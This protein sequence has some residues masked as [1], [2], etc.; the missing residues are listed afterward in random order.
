MR[1]VLFVIPQMKTAGTEKALLGLLEILPADKYQ[2]EIRMV[3]AQGGLLGSIQKNVIVDELP[4]SDKNK[5]IL[6][7]GGTKATILKYLKKFKLI[8]AVK[9]FINKRIKKMPVAELL[10]PFS[11]LAPLKEEYDLAVCFTMHF[12]F[13][14]QY[15]ARKVKAKKKAVWIHNDFSTTSLH[16]EYM[17][18]DLKQYDKIFAVSKQL[19]QE[20]IERCPELKDK[21][22][23][24]YNII[25]VNA[26]KSAADENIEDFEFDG[27]KIL[28]VGRLNKQKGL[29]ILIKVA[30]A[31]KNDGLSF[32][33]Y[34]IGEGE[35]YKSLKKEIEKRELSSYVY[36][37]GVKSNPYPYFK[38]C[39]IYVQPSRHEGYCTTVNEAR[40]LLK[41]I[42]AT[43]VA[44][45]GEMIEN[46]KTGLICKI[47]VEDIYKAVSRLIIDKSLRE[48]LVEN[49]KKTDFS[50]SNQLSLFE[51]LF[52]N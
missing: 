22:E 37:L 32:K 39:D 47:S 18:E 36:L 5:N 11:L 30:Q 19:K 13:I 23:L 49:L 46:E 42:V 20:F 15:V 12:P 48:S 3:K 21:T 41:P 16:P 8:S 43:D 35:L 27:I 9:V 2:T 24:F 14:V 4:L 7:A 52:D 26:I 50:N 45:T 44:G 40:V 28:T 38:K 51:G 34:I 25:D 29:D 17:L 31:L 6:M 10:Q 1:K 33:W